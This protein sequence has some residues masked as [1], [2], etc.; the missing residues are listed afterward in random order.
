M[1]SWALVVCNLCAFILIEIKV[2]FISEGGCLLKGNRSP[3]F[4]VLFGLQFNIY[5]CNSVELRNKCLGTWNPNVETFLF[6][7]SGSH[8]VVAPV[9][10]QEKP[11]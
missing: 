1:P 9:F 2:R 5:L 11:I 3:F 6:G 8:R 4:R 10:Y 7:W